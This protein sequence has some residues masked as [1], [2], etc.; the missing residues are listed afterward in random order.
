MRGSTGFTGIKQGTDG[1]VTDSAGCSIPVT[2]NIT[3]YF[4]V[5]PTVCTFNQ[6]VS[7]G[8]NVYVPRGGSRWTMDIVLCFKVGPCTHKSQTLN[9]K[10]KDGYSFRSDR[11]VGDKNPGF[12]G[13]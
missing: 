5:N 6:S 2:S 9:F 4:A 1:W 12:G 8:D 10:S 3:G 7:W 13:P 11:S